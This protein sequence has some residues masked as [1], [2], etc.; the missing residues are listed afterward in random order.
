MQNLWHFYIGMFVIALGVSACGGPV[1]MVATATWFDRRRARAL[2][3]LTVGGAVAGLG[4][5]VVAWLG[6]S[7]G[8]RD[9]L[10]TS[11]AILSSAC[12]LRERARSSRRPPTADG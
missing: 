9:G 1:G 8:W 5:P 10:R 3:Y 7:C 2:S 6:E 4:V 11:V 12:C